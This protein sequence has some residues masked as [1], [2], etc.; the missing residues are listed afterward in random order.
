MYVSAK[1]DYSILNH[2][3]RVAMHAPAQVLF[4]QSKVQCF[5]KLS[6]DLQSKY[7]I[8]MFTSVQYR[9]AD[10][11][12][13]ISVKKGISTFGTVNIKYSVAFTI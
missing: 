10:A 4:L 13:A 7:V 12:E 8:Y 11:F 5:R 3:I 2:S 1:R 9:Y 6:L